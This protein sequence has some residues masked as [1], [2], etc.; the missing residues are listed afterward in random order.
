MVKKKEKEKYP[1]E[2][3]TKVFKILVMKWQ[4]VCLFKFHWPKQNQ[5]TVF[6]S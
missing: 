3:V 4:K 1:L 5:V 6:S 2:K